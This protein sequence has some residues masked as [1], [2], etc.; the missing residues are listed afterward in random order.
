[1]S[2]EQDFEQLTSFLNSIDLDTVPRDW[3]ERITELFHHVISSNTQ[4]NLTRITSFREFLFK[5]IADSILLK[6]VIPRIKNESL[7]IADV[8]CGAGFPG[9]PLALFFFRSTFVEI[10]SNRRKG[11]FVKSL[12]HSLNLTNCIAVTGRARELA[13]T[14]EFKGKFD[15][16]L[17][18]A[19]KTTA[20]MI[21]ECRHLLRPDT[22]ILAVYKT[23]ATV[24]LERIVA[25]REASKYKLH[26]TESPVFA[27]PNNYGRRQ[28]H[29]VA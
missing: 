19:V 20:V 16:V 26:L 9:I 27:L 22:G 28:F 23:P 13:R 18:R 10:E 8:G 6:R 24:V 7:T 5:H 15:L 29:L 3:A 21:R 17:A 4:F 2:D 11:A 14:P 25:S 1:M 12:I